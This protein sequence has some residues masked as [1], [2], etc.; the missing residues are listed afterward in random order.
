MSRAVLVDT[1]RCI[2]CR[3]CQ[4]ACKEQNRNRTE[5]T[6]FFAAPG[7]YQNPPALSATTFTLVTYHELATPRGD[8]R[9]VFAKRQC[10]HCVDPACVADCPADALRRDTDGTVAYTQARCIGC[11]NCTRACPFGVPVLEQRAAGPFVWKCTFCQDR[12]STASVPD[13]LNQG[14]RTP[15]VLDDAKRARHLAVRRTPACVAA[16][17]TGALQHGERDALLEEARRRIARRPDRYVDH[18][19]GEREGGGTSWLYLASVPFADIGLP[20]RFEPRPGDHEDELRGEW[21]PR[22][23]GAGALVGGLCWYTRRRERV[24]A[25]ESPGAEDSSA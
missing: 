1:T 17:P 20:T 2:G 12:V 3:G 25:A 9:W 22:A 5:S 4:V 10:M 8:P 16:C 18:I 13:V 14:Q 23:L 19:Y 7:G 11:G 6:T 15:D 24:A 21:P